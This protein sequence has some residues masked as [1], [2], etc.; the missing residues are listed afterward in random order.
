VPGN[1]DIHAGFGEGSSVGLAD[2]GV[3]GCDDGVAGI[4][5]HASDIPN[6][7]YRNR[8]VANWSCLSGR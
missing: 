6:R 4:K 2:P 8:L 5:S 7:P 1:V 3:R